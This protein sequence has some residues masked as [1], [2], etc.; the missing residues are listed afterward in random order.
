MTSTK[1]LRLS[2]Y[3]TAQA[4]LAQFDRSAADRDA[5]EAMLNTLLLLNE[6][7]VSAS[8]RNLL[9]GFADG[10]KGRHRRVALF[11]EREFPEKVFFQSQMT[12][13]KGGR[14]RS[15]AFGRVGPAVVK[16]ARGATRVGSEGFIA[17]IISTV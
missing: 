17:S 3:P 12:P 14:A 15:R 4:W 6:E 7:Q 16:P 13:D 8:I 11:A 1:H 10:R 9:Y 5:A 2:S